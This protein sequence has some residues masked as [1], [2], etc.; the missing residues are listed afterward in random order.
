LDYTN[1]NSISIIIVSLEYSEPVTSMAGTRIATPP[2]Y[3]AAS[4]PRFPNNDPAQIPHRIVEAIKIIFAKNPSALRKQR[5]AVSARTNDGSVHVK[6]HCERSKR[7]KRLLR[8]CVR[9]LVSS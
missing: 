8:D 1:S 4:A 7:G 9:Y 5:V 3:R 6:Q 2:Q